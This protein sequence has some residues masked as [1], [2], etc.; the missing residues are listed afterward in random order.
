MTKP[1]VLVVDDDAEFSASLRDVLRDHG[2]RVCLAHDE[3]QA[4]KR[5][6]GRAFQ[7]V[8]ID[9]KLPDGDGTSVY[10]RVR[11]TCPQARTVVITGYPAEM[12]Y[13]IQQLM[14]D[15][16]DAAFYKPLDIS[17]LLAGLQTLRN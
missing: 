4:A 16:A 10:R 2:Y 5:L 13:L 15:G 17:R 14:A 12:D 1:V 9:M 11:E 7:V 8:L 6:G 3:D